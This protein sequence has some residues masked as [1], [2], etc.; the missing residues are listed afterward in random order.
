M[1]QLN[2]LILKNKLLK[3]IAI[4]VIKNINKVLYKDK[5]TNQL[6]QNFNAELSNNIIEYNERRE[7]GYALQ[8]C[9]APFSSLYF[10]VNGDVVACCKNGKD[11]YGN[12]NE[13]KLHEIWHSAIKK[14]LQKKIAEYQLDNGCQFCKSQLNAKNYSAV[15]AR[16]HDQP[17]PKKNNPFPLDITFEISNT[18]NLECI[19]CGGDFSSLIR[20]N[21]DKLPPILNNYPADFFEQLKPFLINLKSARFQGGEPFL[22]KE[23]I[24]ILEYITTNNQQCKIYIQTNGTILNNRV[25]QILNNNSIYLSISMDSLKKDTFEYIRKNSNFTSFSENLK[26]FTVLAKKN[27]YTLNINFCLMNINWKEIPEL[28]EF[29]FQNNYSLNIIP[30]DYPSILS[31]FHLK[32]T[33]I[34]TVLEYLE[35]KINLVHKK[36]FILEYTSL[37]NY[38]NTLKICTKKK[39]TEIETLTQQTETELYE[40]IQEYLEKYLPQLN[41]LQIIKI[42]KEKLFSVNE[43]NKK[44]ILANSIINN[45]VLSEADKSTEYYDFLFTNK[46]IEYFNFEATLLK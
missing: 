16:I 30:I 41:V 17:F 14:S 9:Q 8:F 6:S 29:C 13:K 31:L 10:R 27:K 39:E 43:V 19:M 20:K 37:F 23:Y 28:F 35:T 1:L 40:I 2:Q 36:K 26:H 7:F 4:Q 11:I 32:Y 38:I 45:R 33:E 21:R 46:L 34:I 42:Y 3:R 25:K 22:I 18:C 5:I 15:H 12:L 44:I 24:D